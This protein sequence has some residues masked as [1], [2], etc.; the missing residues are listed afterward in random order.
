MHTYTEE[1]H[2]QTAD[3]WKFGSGGEERASV[4]EAGVMI[5]DDYDDGSCWG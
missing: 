5:P 3:I 4:S 1:E 2:K